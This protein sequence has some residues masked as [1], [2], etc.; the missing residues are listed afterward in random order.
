MQAVGSRGGICG[1]DAES[2]LEGRAVAPLV[3]CLKGGVREA[4]V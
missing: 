4:P 1:C 2:D 3:L